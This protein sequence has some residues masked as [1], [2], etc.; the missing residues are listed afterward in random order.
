[1]WLFVLQMVL[2]SAAVCLL[3]GFGLWLGAD[4]CN[5]ALAD[6]FASVTKNVA[7]RGI[8]FVAYS[9][10]TVLIDSGMIFGLTALCA[11][12]PLLILKKI[13]PREI[14]CAKE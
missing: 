12:V 7:M 1:M 9:W 2:V 13:K 3:S 14:I 6:G 11:V 5:A 8:R 10:T 4:V